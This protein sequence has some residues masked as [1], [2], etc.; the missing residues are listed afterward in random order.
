VCSLRLRKKNE[1]KKK[2]KS[3]SQPCPQQAPKKKLAGNV[4][5]KK[6]AISHLDMEVEHA[7]TLK[8]GEDVVA[9]D[10]EL[11]RKIRRIEPSQFYLSDEPEKETS[12]KRMLRKLHKPIREEAEEE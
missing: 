11:P 3:S 12:W 7:E 5:K 10:H 8:E 2:K 1:A 4:Q 9:K 6:K